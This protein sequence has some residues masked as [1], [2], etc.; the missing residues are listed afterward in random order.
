MKLFEIKGQTPNFLLTES[1]NTHMEHLEDLVFNNGYAGGVEALNYADS[2]RSMLADGQG[3]IGKITVKW[4]GSPAIICGTDPKD[5]KF[6]VG[7]KS[8]FAKTQPKL[9]KSKRDVDK[10][11]GEVP[12]LA[13][14]LLTALSNLKKL[15]IGQVLQ[16]DM[17]FMEGTKQTD[18]I[19]G[20][21]YITFTPNT[22]TYA[23]ESN[24]KLGQ[25]ISNAKFGIVFHTTYKGD[26]LEEMKADYSVNIEGLNKTSDVWFDDATYKDLTGI[27]SLTPK[28]DKNL[29]A[30]MG[31]TMRTMEKLGPQ[32]FNVVLEN[33]EFA[34]FIK[35]FIN[36]SV[37]GGDQT[38]NPSQF[39]KDFVTYYNDQMMKDI[40]PSDSDSRKAKNRLEKIESKKQWIGDNVNNLVGVLAVYKRLVEIK[41]ILIEKLQQVEGI[42]TFQK[43]NDGYKV[44]NPE[45]FVAIGHE[46]GAVKLVDRL[47][48]S[49]QNFQKAR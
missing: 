1:K 20:E 30:L 3:N 21:N 15:G 16:G 6:F 11:Y 39:I 45:G 17:M 47:T 8:V 7:T 35:P 40:E 10:F 18:D 27:A 28:E 42:R 46:G 19:D 33:K 23:V 5:G 31:A 29:T 38:P 41:Q 2:V 34:K 37:R 44:T 22:I 4:D 25:Q 9:C 24:S 26:S 36:K 14:I 13:N 43:T 48:F 49:R 32:R 12:E